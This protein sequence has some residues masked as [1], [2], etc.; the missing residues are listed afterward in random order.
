MAFCFCTLLEPPPCACILVR[1]ATCGRYTLSVSLPALR[2]GT[3]TQLLV[4]AI[5][6]LH[7]T[8]NVT[9]PQSF[10]TAGYCQLC[11]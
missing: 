3:R 11:L 5:A 8:M 6:L 2:H 4:L 7:R 1:N 9:G 10:L